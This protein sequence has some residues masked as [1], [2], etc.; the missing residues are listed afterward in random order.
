MS[1]QYEQQVR[2]RAYAIWEREG[3][4]GNP[5]EHWAQAEQELAATII[6]GGKSADEKAA[7][8]KITRKLGDFA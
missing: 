1:Q 2:E 6:E 3:R 8:D 5:H 7:E 4:S